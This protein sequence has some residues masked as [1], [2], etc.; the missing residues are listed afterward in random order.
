M[1]TWINLR[2]DNLDRKHAWSTAATRRSL[3]HRPA[4]PLD[5]PTR[6]DAWWV[7]LYLRSLV[8]KGNTVTKFR[9]IWR[10]DLRVVDGPYDPGYE[11]TFACD[12]GTDDEG[13][14]CP[15]H[16]FAN[17]DIPN[18]RNSGSRELMTILRTSFDPVPQWLDDS[19]WD[20]G[21]TSSE[22]QDGLSLVS[23]QM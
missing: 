8:L 18:V 23:D 20:D 5:R 4:W 19:A 12:P 6:V 7:S 15:V 2:Y 10:I 11:C 22:V 9:R 17:I 14:N 16:V 13:L 21:H 1:R 3:D